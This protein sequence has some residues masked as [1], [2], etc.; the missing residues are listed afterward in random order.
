M[1]WGLAAA[2]GAPAMARMLAQPA[3][4]DGL[5]PAD[6][7]L[8]T[9]GRDEAGLFPGQAL[10][11]GGQMEIRL[12]QSVYTDDPDE[13]EVAQ[14]LR[15]FNIESWWQE[16]SR[17]AEKN[18]RMADEYAAAGLRVSANGFYMRA[19][20]FYREANFYLPEHHAQQLPTYRKYRETFDR[21]WEMVPPPF[22]RVTVNIGG[23]ALPGYFRKPGGAQGRRFPTV[24]GVQGADSMAENTIMGGAS[25]YVARGMAYLVVDLPGM[26]GAQRLHNLYLPPDTETVVSPLIDYLETRPDVDTSRIGVVGISM[27]GYSAPRAAASEDRIAAVWMA[28]GSYNLQQDI[29]DYYPPLQDR[30]RWIIGAP[31][32]AQARRRL[33]EY[34]L[35]GIAQNIRCPMLIGYGADDRIMD[36]QGAFRLHEAAVN[37]PREMYAGGGH[38]HHSAKAGG[39][40]EE[41]LPTLQDWAMLTLNANT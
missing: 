26:G 34:S 13:L 22:E 4:A 38:P 16:W 39:P 28:S 21:A 37:A 10:P 32:L 25:G 15:P 18:E 6:E 9:G 1:K 17:V 29:F 2:A 23:N 41:S 31:D 27:G 14:R 36:P 33:A 8:I 35:E 7:L 19:S 40:R 12:V 30:L 5:G 20:R 11:G 24:I 3:S